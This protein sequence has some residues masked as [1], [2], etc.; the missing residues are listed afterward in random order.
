MLSESLSFDS[1]NTQWQK[2]Q[3]SETVLCRTISDYMPLTPVDAKSV[4]AKSVWLCQHLSEKSLVSEIPLVLCLSGGL[5]SQAVLHSFISSGVS[6][7]IAILR[8]KNR[9]NFHDIEE[10]LD[11]AQLSG[12]KT[13]VID[14]DAI[15]FF[16]SGRFSDYADRSQTNSPQFALH[17]WFAEQIEGLPIFAGEPYYWMSVEQCRVLY[18]PQ[19]K[20]YAARNL[21]E[22]SGRP[23]ISHF[24]ELLTELNLCFLENPDWSR[25][26]SQWSTIQYAKKAAGYRALGFPVRDTARGMKYTGFEGLYWHFRMKYKSHDTYYFNKLFR[27]PLEKIKPSPTR[28]ELKFDALAG[29]LTEKSQL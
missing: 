25:E 7:E 29:L 23:C 17:A 26:K 14:I 21:L 13:H 27:E 10:A 28:L 18:V 11:L 6:F 2:T 3:G 8:F 20:E 24:F 12:V 1:K 9:L 5:D 15:N 16:E 22:L 19:P 4:F